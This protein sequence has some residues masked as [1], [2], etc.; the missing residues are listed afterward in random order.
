[1]SLEAGPWGCRE[2]RDVCF[3]ENVTPRPARTDRPP[4][5]VRN[6]AWIMNRCQGRSLCPAEPWK[7]VFPPPALTSRQAWS[8][9]G[10]KVNAGP[11]FPAR[12]GRGRQAAQPGAG[13]LAA[14]GRPAACGR[15]RAFQ[16]PAVNTRR[17]GGRDGPLRGTCVL[18][19][20]GSGGGT[21]FRPWDAGRRGAVH[22]SV[23]S[24]V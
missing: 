2:G 9:E 10:E 11:P 22:A 13:V 19:R 6:W 24:P 1:M 14:V 12:R 21:G 7:T 3:R 23:P 5:V 17:H 8:Q 15:S 16:V 20:E 18:L 4:S